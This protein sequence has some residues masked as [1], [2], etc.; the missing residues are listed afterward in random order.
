MARVAF[1]AFD[2]TEAAQIRRIQSVRSIGHDVV[3]YAFRRD[4]MNSHFVPDWTNIP[5][6]TT[7]NEGF[8]RRLGSIGIGIVRGLR[9]RNALKGSEVWIARNLDLLAVAWAL[10]VG[11]G[12][13]DVSLVYE[14]LDIHGLMTRS[15]PIG[16]VMRWIERRLLAHTTLLIV[17]SPGFLREYFGPIQGY[18]GKATLIE[19][20]LWIGD[21]ALPRP[22]VPRRREGPFVLGWVGSLRCA[23]SLRILCTAA[24]MLGDRVRIVLHGNVHR[25]ALPDFDA[26]IAGRANLT[27]HGPYAYP[28]DLREIYGAC[29]L[30]WAQDLWQRGANSD[31]LLPNR[32]YEAG[33]F[34]C[35]SIALAGTETG[36]RV[37]ED[38]LGFTVDEPSAR[39][40]TDLLRSLDRNR[41]IEVSSA[42]LGRPE[43]AF[44]LDP[45]DLT[46]ALAPVFGTQPAD[47]GKGHARKEMTT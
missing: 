39:A 10:K 41:I 46:S 18:S 6:G 36:R 15:G 47:Q 13:A 19:N 20:K 3:S 38:G 43:G 12:R 17:S 42:L 8:L 23:E 25:H 16:A 9:N 30:V 1:F 34:G 21:R 35:P 26:V 40:L 24:D 31:W 4:N 11:T 7:R 32:I 33:Y 14:C 45:A 44:R 5:L 37:A 2:I 27:H 29:D 28:E 22:A